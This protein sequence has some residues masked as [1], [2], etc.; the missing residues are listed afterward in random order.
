MYRAI[1]VQY[2][3]KTN[4]K[5]FCDTIATSIVRYEKHR[6]W[7]SK[8]GSTQRANIESQEKKTRPDVWQGSAAWWKSLEIPIISPEFLTPLPDLNSQSH[9]RPFQLPGG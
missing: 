6:C 9:G 7:A 1:I 5:H 4:A 8:G 2:P 3:I